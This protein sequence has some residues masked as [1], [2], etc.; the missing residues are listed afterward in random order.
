MNK[1][2]FNCKGLGYIKIG[3]SRIPCPT[4]E[5]KQVL[6]EKEETKLTKRKFLVTYH[7]E[8]EVEADN[9]NDAEHIASEIL[10][11]DGIDWWKFKTKE[12]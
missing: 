3:V 10:F 11:T 2:C 7:D 8:I 12:I 4:C 1:L 6:T 9:E 5:G